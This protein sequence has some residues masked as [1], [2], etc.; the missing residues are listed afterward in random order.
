M[1]FA[2]LSKDWRAA[3]SSNRRYRHGSACAEALCFIRAI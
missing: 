3:D 2:Y 1:P